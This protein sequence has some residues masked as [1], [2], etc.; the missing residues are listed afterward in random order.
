MDQAPYNRHQKQRIATS[1]QNGPG[2]AFG[3]PQCVRSYQKDHGPIG[4]LAHSVSQ[5]TL[6]VATASHSA[7]RF[8]LSEQSAPEASQP[9]GTT[10]GGGL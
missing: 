5:I 4:G 8:T 2:C 7:H 10:A 6:F 1:I 3:P 9:S